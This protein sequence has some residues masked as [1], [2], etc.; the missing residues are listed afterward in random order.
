MINLYYKAPQSVKNDVK[1]N[2]LKN[3]NPASISWI[4]TFMPS[5]EEEA[6]INNLM[7]VNLISKEEASEIESSSKYCELKEGVVININFYE[8]HQNQFKVE[9]ITFI[10]NN[11][12]ALI[13][14]RHN[15]CGVFDETARRLGLYNM[16]SLSGQDILMILI[17]SHIDREADL[18]E[19]LATRISA[20][21]DSVNQEE[22]VGK[23][24]IKQISFL[25]SKIITFRENIF[26]LQR[27]L[28]SIRRSS[29]FEK[30]IKPTL[31]LMI[32]DTDSLINHADFSSQRLD[33]I[34]DTA[35]GLINIEQN[36]IM[37]ILSI[38][39]VIFMP[40][41]L[42]ASIYGMN[43]KYMPELDWSYT[44][45]SGSIIP[46]G[47]FFALALMLT[48]AVCTILYCR[49]KKWL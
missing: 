36:E 44:T 15:K 7:N 2:D 38:A 3:L 13:T 1:I 9:P 18:M 5:A 29:R 39:A 8:E 43:F 32:Q 33:S 46:M 30:E 19:A 14:I 42:V 6:V 22:N 24:K 17:E 31:Q 45:E 4:D 27:I 49:H 21:A 34:Q 40:P 10:L 25:Q 28:F 26:D 23:E 41:T 35:I 48:A 11:Q 20:L 47:Y 37:K 16:E 12:N